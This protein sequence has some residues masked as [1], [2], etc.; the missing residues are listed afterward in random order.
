MVGIAQPNVDIVFKADVV[1]KHRKAKAAMQHPE[2]HV[3]RQQERLW[4]HVVAVGIDKASP[5][6]TIQTHEINTLAHPKESGI[7]ECV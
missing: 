5:L 2:R 1:L 3:A 7:G 4:R 6:L